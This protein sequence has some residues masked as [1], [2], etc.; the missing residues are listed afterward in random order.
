MNPEKD[1][2]QEYKAAKTK[3]ARAWIIIKGIFMLTAGTLLFF[4]L[5]SVKALLVI[6]CIAFIAGGAN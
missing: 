2:V 3:Q 4:A 6:A 5:T 1:I